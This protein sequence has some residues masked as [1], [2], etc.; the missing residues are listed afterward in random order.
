MNGVDIDVPK[1][2]LCALLGP[3]GCGKST[4]LRVIAG[5]E[6]PD[7]GRIF[8]DD[9]DV[10]ERPLGKRDVGFVF[11]NYA[12]FPH[13]TVAQNVAFSLAVRKRPAQEIRERVAE[14]LA[15]VQLSGYEAR[16]P[17]ELSGGQRQRVALARSL[18]SKPAVLLL[19]EPFA[20]LDAN[21]RKDLRRSLRELHERTHVTTLL[22]THD[23]EEALEV[24][25]HIIVLKDG[26][27]Q[28]QAPP[29][30]IYAEPANPFVMGFFGDVNALRGTG[31]TTYVRPADV[32][33]ETK[34][35]REAQT[36][37]VL[38]V[39][40]AG[41]RTQFD[42]SLDDGQRIVA[43]CNEDRAGWLALRKGMIVYVEPVKSRSFDEVPA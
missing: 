6:A 4:L 19:D 5:F 24:A 40:T 35:F 1:G 22:V 29:Q 31:T 33:I 2:S 9:I 42:L 10:T 32:R 25:D 38:D 28:Q 14:L 8:L 21:V 16:R 11:Q 37:H 12:L 27:V 17:H 7:A 43:E 23:A 15:T 26:E 36:A 34:P 39:R 30:R 18:A 41:P 20:A 13:Q 3:S